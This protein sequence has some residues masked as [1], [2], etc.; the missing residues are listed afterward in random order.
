MNNKKGIVTFGETIPLSCAPSGAYYW[1]GAPS[2]AC[3]AAAA[4]AAC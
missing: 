1:A 2:A 4:A 3:C